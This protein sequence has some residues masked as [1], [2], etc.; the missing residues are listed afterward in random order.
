LIKFRHYS[1]ADADDI[2]GWHTEHLR[3]LKSQKSNTEE[4]S[5]GQ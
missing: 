3:M 2:D 4:V 1:K 5:P